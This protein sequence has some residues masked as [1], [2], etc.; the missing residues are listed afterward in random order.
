MKS[1]LR[2]F[3]LWCLLIF[4][5]YCGRLTLLFYFGS[6][7]IGL[8]GSKWILTSFRFDVMTAAH[9]ILPTAILSFFGLFFG[10]GKFL[11]RLKRGYFSFILGFSIFL[12][13]LNVVFFSEYKSQFNQWILGIFYDDFAAIMLTII[14]SYPITLILAGVF[15]IV[16][17]SR[18]VSK[19]VF[20]RTAAVPA[21]KSRYS[22]FA[23][24]ALAVPLFLLCMRG[25]KIEGK[26]LSNK[27]AV[28][29]DSAF[30]NNL[31]PTS[32][33]CIR[34]ELKTHFEFL[35]FDDSLEYFETS[36]AQIPSVLT[37]V[38]GCENP[39]SIDDALARRAGGALIKSKPPHIFLII[40]ESHSAWPLYEK[41][42]GRN[43]MPQ[44]LAIAN[45]SLRSL[46]TLSAGICTVDSVTSILGGVPFAMLSASC[47]GNYPKDFSIA[48]YAKALG[49]KTRFFCEVS[50]DWCNIAQFTSSIGFDQNFGGDIMSDEYSHHA[51]GVPDREFFQY[52][53]GVN[54]D[55]PT[56]NVIL[57][58]SNHPPYDVD[59]KAEGCPN[60]IDSPMENKVQ[61]FW[62][63]DKQIGDFVAKMRERF[64][65]AI[66]IITGDHCARLNPEYLGN[67]F[68]NRM[69]VPLIFAGKPIEDANLVMEAPC[70]S[71]M[72]IIPTLIELIAP[73]GF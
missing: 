27:D 53:S 68:E 9:L 1:L 54:Y 60:K 35:S 44:T 55:S 36:S 10:E 28:I 21:F 29:S 38:F 16:V 18:A 32:A 73:A 48:K 8:I 17:L 39:K 62:Y 30:L 43:L 14:K 47:V 25:G 4:V 20:K 26:P 15:F 46:H 66:F 71:H 72:D 37:D 34:H 64:P 51:W 42:I 2:D 49:Y 45:S 3:I 67:E 12:S 6:D 23:A 56:L 63:A 19:F 31:I 41:Y 57:T 5:Y 58:G 24:L 65:D 70:A 7:S 61:H 22:K 52:I 59:L 69:C 13:V 11:E 40:A 50:L 33:Y